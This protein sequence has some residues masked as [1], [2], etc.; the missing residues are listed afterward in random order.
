MMF[1]RW[2]T[3]LFTTK[4]IT[5]V[6]NDHLGFYAMQKEKNT[7]EEELSLYNTQD[8]EIAPTVN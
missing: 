8:K 7:P 2:D 4:L 3:Y 6:G 1:Q 5:S